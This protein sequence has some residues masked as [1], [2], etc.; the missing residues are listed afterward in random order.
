MRKVGFHYVKIGLVLL[1]TWGFVA[2]C[3]SI[4]QGISTVSDLILPQSH[5]FTVIAPAEYPASLNIKSIEVE[6][7]E[8]S[9]GNQVFGKQ[10]KRIIESD[11]ANEGYLA[12]MNTGADTVVSGTI[13]VGEIRKKT[14]SG[15]ASAVSQKIGEETSR[16]IK[17]IIGD[18]DSGSSEDET[19]YIH[20]KEL[21]ITGDYAL[22][23]NRR[24]TRITGDSFSVSFDDRWQSSDSAIQAEAKA[25][26]DEVIV[27]ELLG[28]I[29]KDIVKTVSPHREQVTRRLEKGSDK[30]IRLGI[31]YLKNGRIEQAMSIWDQVAERTAESKDKASALY[32]IGVIKEA[33]GKYV[34]AFNLFSQANALWP[35]RELYMQAM[36]RVEEAKRKREIR[37]RQVG[38]AQPL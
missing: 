22:H 27:H 3:A 30:S 8:V 16:I 35:E 15:K 20:T 18:D 5:T 36:T 9:G 32:N 4:E 13:H 24:D 23:D 2:G 14:Y 17:D 25:P 29:V 38:G 12:V 26:P 28:N 34:D 7:F 10:L 11:I 33:Q 21:T 6:P 31:T 19:V 37:D 1:L